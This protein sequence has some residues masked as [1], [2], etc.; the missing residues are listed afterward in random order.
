MSRIWKAS[1]V[2]A[3]A[4]AMM[5]CAGNEEEVSVEETTEVE[6]ENDEVEIVITEDTVD[7]SGYYIVVED[8]VVAIGSTLEDTV[9]CI[10]EEADYFEAASCAYEGTDYIYTYN[11]CVITF[12]DGDEDVSVG[13]ISLKNDIIETGE[14]AY[15]GLSKEDVIAIYG[16]NYEGDDSAITYTKDNSELQ[17]IFSDDVVISILIQAI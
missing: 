5:G 14:G 3:M 9:E 15:I 11:N 1:L 4:F 16:D 13:S 2:V 7:I 6:T 17:F 10:E 8:V 12:Y